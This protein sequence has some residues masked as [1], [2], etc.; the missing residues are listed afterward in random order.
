MITIDEAILKMN[1]VYR[2]V[3]LDQAVKSMYWLMI[4]EMKRDNDNEVFE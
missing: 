1:Q 2:P 3:T 4:E